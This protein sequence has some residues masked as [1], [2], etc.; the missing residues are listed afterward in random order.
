MSP[1]SVRTHPQSF[2]GIAVVGEAVHRVTPE[3]AEFLVEFTA[4]GQSASQAL[5]N[6][7]N[8]IAQIAQTLSGA[9]RAD[10]QTVSLNVANV[11]SPALGSPAFG[12]PIPQI[13][14]GAIPGFASP[15]ALQPELQFGAFQA[16]STLRVLVREAARAGEV[17]DLL[18]KAGANLVAGI[19][20]RAGDEAGARRSA[21]E[22]AGKDA[23]SK[24][25]SLA[26]AAGK[27]VGDPLGIAEEVI[28]S[29]GVYSAIRSQMPWAFGPNAPAAVGELEYYAR[30]TASFRFQ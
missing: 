29:N 30:V 6:H 9:H 14:P 4:S 1:N 20:Y 12:I 23:R 19:S 2:E 25:E 24:A 15:P 7:Q 17:A 22:A 8:L 10:L 3:S 11:Y 13:S 21:L 26:A 27:Q 28:A 5:T 16:R 18:A